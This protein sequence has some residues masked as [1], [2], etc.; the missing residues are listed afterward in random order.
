MQ[1][2]KWVNFSL[3]VA[4][5]LVFL[6]LN[7]LVEALWNLVLLPEMA[8]WVVAP[9][10]LIAFVFAAGSGLL[11]RQNERSN[12]FLNEVVLELSKVSWPARDETFKSAGV[13]AVLV[14]IASLI[15]FV[16]DALWGTII[17]GVLS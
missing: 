1:T 14:G 4:S 9:A 15:L 7:R 17:R 10:T 5:F 2:Q 8:D 12:G 13:V 16:V 3:L 11:A 6:F